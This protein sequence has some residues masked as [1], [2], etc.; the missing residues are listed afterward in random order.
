MGTL[1][2]APGLSAMP[3]PAGSSR[4]SSAAGTTMCD[5]A[6]NGP[7]PEWVGSSGR[8]WAGTDTCSA[9]LPRSYQATSCC[10]E[11]NAGTN[12]APR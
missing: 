3:M 5:M 4:A 2:S 10:A 6:A 9:T 11:V 8:C 7:A 12:S 1:A